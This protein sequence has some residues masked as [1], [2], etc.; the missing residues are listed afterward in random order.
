MSLFNFSITTSNE[1]I[2][3]SLV[4]KLRLHNEPQEFTHTRFLNFQ[5]S[6]RIFYENHRGRFAGARHGIHWVV[7]GTGRM[8]GYARW[9][10]VIVDRLQEIRLPW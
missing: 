5:F 7:F 3:E 10:R 4:K 6:P 1:N 2:K 8:A 9:R